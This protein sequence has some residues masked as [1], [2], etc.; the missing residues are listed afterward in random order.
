MGVC[1]YYMCM[2]EQAEQIE[3]NVIELRHSCV[4]FQFPF[5]GSKQHPMAP[6]VVLG[7]L[8]FLLLFITYCLWGLCASFI[9]QLPSS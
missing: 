4:E 9:Q 2:E 3:F 7:V 1:T 6:P 5:A 8:F